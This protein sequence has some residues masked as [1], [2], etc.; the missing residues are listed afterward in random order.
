MKMSLAEIREYTNNFLKE[1]YGA[2]LNIPIKINGRLTRVLGRFNYSSK[3]NKPISIEVS[4]KYLM[5]GNIKDIK[6]TLRH[7]AIHYYLHGQDRDFK[8]GD[9]DFEN[10]LRKH[11]THST[12]TV[13]YKRKRL[14]V[15]HECECGNQWIRQ[16]SMGERY[17]CASCETTIKEVKREYVY[18]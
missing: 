13:T 1:A 10:E 2:E 4:K 6:S 17:M 15:T 3:D 7:E 18:R 16:R 11:N 14:K 9:K 8:D 12:G 5:N